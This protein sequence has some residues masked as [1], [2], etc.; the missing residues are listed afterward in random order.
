VRCYRLADSL[1][2]ADQQALVQVIDSMLTKH[3]MRSLLER[4]A[5]LPG[6]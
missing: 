1:D 3:R 5:A 6:A 4:G 2:E